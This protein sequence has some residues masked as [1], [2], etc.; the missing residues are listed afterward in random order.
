MK[1]FSSIKLKENHVEVGTGTIK[2]ELDKKL[3]TRK[4]FFPPNP[5]IGS[6]CSVGE[7]AWKQFK[8]VGV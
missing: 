7:N 2:G 8:Q 6:F 5:S 1:N 4:K 3:E